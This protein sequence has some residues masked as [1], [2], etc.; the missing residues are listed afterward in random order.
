[1]GALFRQW[2]GAE[3]EISGATVV[4]PAA[5]VAAASAIAAKPAKAEVQP[6]E[7]V[8]FT[9]T[10]QSTAKVVDDTPPAKPVETKAPKTKPSQRL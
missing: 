2:F 5:G 3:E 4:A 10:P 7:P 8:A 1:M 6:A 9:A